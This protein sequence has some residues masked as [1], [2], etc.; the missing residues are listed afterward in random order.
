M[1]AIDNLFRIK[2]YLQP[3]KDRLRS[4]VSEIAIEQH[5]RTDERMTAARDDDAKY[6]VWEDDFNARPHYLKD[7]PIKIPDD[8][9]DEACRSMDARGKLIASKR[10]PLDAVEAA[11]KERGLSGLG[12]KPQEP[13]RKGEEQPKKKPADEMP[14]V[15][16]PYHANWKA[17]R[18][19]KSPEDREEQRRAAI[20]A[21]FRTIGAKNAAAMAAKHGR[22]V[23]GRPLRKV[24]AR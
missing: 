1:S 2:T 12:A 22:M 11:L 14:G 18:V 13:R 23:D 15:N 6:K 17:P 3:F 19:P 16:N 20:S 21:L 5:E 7:E 4:S 9:A 24:G 10:Y 8:V